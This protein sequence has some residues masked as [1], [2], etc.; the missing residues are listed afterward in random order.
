M[1]YTLC[2]IRRIRWRTYTGY[3]AQHMPYTLENIYRIRSATYAVYAAQHTPYTLRN[4]RPCT[5]CN[6]CHIYSMLR[7]RGVCHPN[8]SDHDSETTFFKKS[9]RHSFKH[10]TTCY[11]VFDRNEPR[12]PDGVHHEPLQPDGHSQEATRN[13]PNE[14]SVFWVMG[15]SSTSFAISSRTWFDS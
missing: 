8:R 14:V 3:A 15:G 12:T 1:A 5:L 2:N 10:Y 11:N 13:P 7:N 6:I 4:N 9:R